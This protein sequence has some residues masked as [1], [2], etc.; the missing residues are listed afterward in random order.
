MYPFSNKF[1]EDDGVA[2]WALQCF[3]KNQCEVR[4]GKVSEDKK[5]YQPIFN[6][7]RPHIVNTASCDGA[8]AALSENSRRYWPTA[9]YELAHET[10]HLLDPI[11]GYTNYL[12]EG[13]AVHFS[14]EMSKL[15]TQHQQQPNCRFYNQAWQLV[16]QLPDDIYQSGAKIRENF[17]SLSK[18]TSAGIKN[19]FP[20]LSEHVAK[21]LCRECNFT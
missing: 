11:A 2:L 21:E 6:G 4:L 10:V 14:V 18:A 20:S 7:D 9:L 12:E 13:L 1:P 16:N 8:F 15:F 17:G 5:I 19:L 3:L